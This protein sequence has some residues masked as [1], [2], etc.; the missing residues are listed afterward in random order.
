M[1]PRFYDHDEHG[2]PGRWIE[3][4]RHT[5]KSLG[6]KVLADRMV[7]DYVHSLYMPATQSARTLNGDY[8][9]AQQLSDWKSRVRSAWSHVRVDH[10]DSSGLGDAPEVGGQLQVHAFVSLGDL[11]PEDVEVQALHG[12]V[13]ETDTLQDVQV[14]PLHRV[15]DLEA[16]RHRFEGTVAF[17]AAGPFGYTVRVLPHSERMVDPAELGV[18]TSA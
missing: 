18:V 15:E 2:L 6:P 16:D 7:S 5:L 12:R 10:V 17:D 3:M 8:K 4:V 9:G 13:R 14:T 11:A 1:A